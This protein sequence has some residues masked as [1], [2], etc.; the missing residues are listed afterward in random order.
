MTNFD[1]MHGNGNDFVVINS[2]EKDLVLRKSLI[3]KLS[4]RKCGIG[5]D[6]LI[7]ISVPVK[8]NHDFSVKFFNA[9][10]GE[11][12]MCLNGIRSA[13]SYIWR[14]DFAPKKS[15]IIK[16]KT[17]LVICKPVGNK[18]RVDIKISEVYKNDSLYKKIS[19][20]ISHQFDF[21]DS[22]NMHLCIKQSSIKNEDINALYKNLARYIKPLK[23]NLSIYR[24]SKEQIDIRTYE[25]GV[26]ETLSCGSAS[27]AVASL[28]I[29]DKCR[30]K[31]SGGALDFIKKN[32]DT[33]EMIGPAEFVFS[34][35]F[36][37]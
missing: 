10:G 35:S 31:S 2:I 13:A 7:L 32:N 26:G 20:D 34:G 22:G 8:D 12:S 27:L 37:D 3:K 4:D 5:F 19:G 15:I 30:V 23:C 28:C 36:D 11:A 25:N 18:I 24:I 14:H 6:Q 1:K 9:D 33:M 29:K 17:R 16:T 21:V